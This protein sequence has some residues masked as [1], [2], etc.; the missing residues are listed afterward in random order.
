MD[1]TRRKYYLNP[2][3]EAIIEEA[4]R[5]I[6][7]RGGVVLAAEPQPF[8]QPKSSVLSYAAG[9]AA[10]LAAFDVKGEQARRQASGASRDSH[11]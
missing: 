1:R 4:D 9:S 8:F 2:D 6:G 5:A 11:R 3:I 10:R 7:R